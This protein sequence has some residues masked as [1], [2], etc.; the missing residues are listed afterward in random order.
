MSSECQI[1]ASWIKDHE[2][3]CT[4]TISLTKKQGH[5]PMQMTFRKKMFLLKNIWPDQVDKRSRIPGL[6]PAVTNTLRV[7][8]SGASLSSS[9]SQGL[10]MQINSQ[11][12]REHDLVCILSCWY[13][14]ASNRASKP[15]LRPIAAP[16]WIRELSCSGCT[17]PVLRM[18]LSQNHLGWKRPLRSSSSVVNLTLPSPPLNHVPKVPHLQVFCIPPGIVTQALPWAACSNAW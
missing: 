18:L 13:T 4:F 12:I 3:L 17:Q 11:Q 1:N 2:L 9:V 8:N 6:W 14:H 7:S 15:L 16:V 10:G 5:Q